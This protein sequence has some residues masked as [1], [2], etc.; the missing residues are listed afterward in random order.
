MNG[1]LFQLTLR[2]WAEVLTNGKFYLVFAIVV[3]CSAAIGPFGTYDRMDLVNRIGFWIL[4]HAGCWALGLGLIVPLR[5]FFES[6]GLTRLASFIVSSGL[7]NLVIGPIFAFVL[8]L[9][10]GRDFSLSVGVQ[11]LLLATPLVVAIT[12]LVISLTG[13]DSFEAVS[14]TGEL[15]L[16]P[17]WA[18]P[19]NCKVQQKLSAANRGVILA[20]IAQDHYVEVITNKG[21]E[22]LLMR[23]GDAV[24]ICGDG[25][26]LRIHRSAWV[27]RSGVSKLEKKG[28]NTKV[29]LPNGR[30]LPVA[31]SMESALSKLMEQH[32]FQRPASMKLLSV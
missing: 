32:P 24:D 8:V 15:E 2:R 3:I 23:L 20:L 28:R 16:L 22:L 14:E 6:L 9:G 17:I 11:N 27:S 4:V 31:R 26:S 7:A 19:E 12:Y 29:V 25:N 1:T 21:S 10:S 30:R 5:L 13:M 18:D